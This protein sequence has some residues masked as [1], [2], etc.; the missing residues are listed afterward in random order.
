MDALPAPGAAGKDV[1]RI[2][3]LEATVQFRLTGAANDDWYVVCD[4]GNITRH[5][6]MSENPIT[7]VT[8]PAD[9]WLSIQ[10]GEMNQFQAWTGGE[11]KIEG[12]HT[13]LQLLETVIS[14]LDS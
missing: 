7:T 2:E 4:K 12:D 9:T 5:A 8:M 1:T 6:G 13:V 14:R 11:L 3:D 10:K